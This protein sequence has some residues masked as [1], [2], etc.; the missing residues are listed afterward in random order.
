MAIA[1]ATDTL[2]ES[3]TLSKDGLLEEQVLENDGKVDNTIQP[4]E[5][6]C[7]FKEAPNIT[8]SYKENYE[9][10]RSSGTFAAEMLPVSC[11]LDIG[12]DPSL[13]CETIRSGCTWEWHL[14][15]AK[16]KVLQY[17]YRLRQRTV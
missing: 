11:V 10:S 1:I 6:I 17:V 13:I 4:Y 9:V 12:A 2:V 16:E 15:A 8:L 3:K 7:I 5:Q 14:T